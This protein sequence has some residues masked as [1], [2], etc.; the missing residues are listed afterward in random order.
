MKNNPSGL[1]NNDTIE[2]CFKRADG[3][4][5]P[6]GSSYSGMMCGRK[7]L[8]RIVLLVREVRNLQNKLIRRSS[9]NTIL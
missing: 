2:D 6:D 7:D 4:A 8:R 3:L 1:Q 9:G 5:K